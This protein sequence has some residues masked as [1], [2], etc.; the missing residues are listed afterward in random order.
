MV[1]PCS[2]P[3]IDD[4]SDCSRLEQ[5]VNFTLELRFIEYLFL[6]EHLP[7]ADNINTEEQ[8]QR[9]VLFSILQLSLFLHYFLFHGHTVEHTVRWVIVLLGLYNSIFSTTE[10]IEWQFFS[11]P[12]VFS[13][14]RTKWLTS[15][16]AEQ[17]WEYRISLFISNSRETTSRRIFK[18]VKLLLQKVETNKPVVKYAYV[19]AKFWSCT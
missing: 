9:S 19:L 16:T 10:Q 15:G 4:F 13:L 11:L 14:C 17:T 3:R 8:H 2:E 5:E 6:C 7:E 18:Y 1:D 12:P